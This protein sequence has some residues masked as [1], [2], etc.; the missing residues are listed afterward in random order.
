MPRTPKNPPLT[1]EDRRRRK[2]AGAWLKACREAR[3][4]SQV[5]VSNLLDYKY[6]TVISAWERGEAIVPI[7]QYESIAALYR[8]PVPQLVRKL[9][10][11]YSP[12]AARLYRLAYSKDAAHDSNRISK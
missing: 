8:I 5:E 7:D 3:D 4:M 12:E 2:E 11:L 6:Y 1:E 9:T 10:G